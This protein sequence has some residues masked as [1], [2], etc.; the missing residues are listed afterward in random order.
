MVMVTFMGLLHWAEWEADPE[1]EMGVLAS[2]W[3]GTHVGTLT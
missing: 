2:D 1:E 3:P